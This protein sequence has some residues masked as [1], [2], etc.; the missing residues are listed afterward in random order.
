MARVTE[1]GKTFIEGFVSLPYGVV[2]ISEAFPGRDMTTLAYDTI[3]E[4]TQKILQEFED[5]YHIRE[6]IENQEIQIIGTS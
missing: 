5:K 4:R 6:A 1:T 2:T 3:V